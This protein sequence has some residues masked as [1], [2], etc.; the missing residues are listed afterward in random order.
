M[1]IVEKGWGREEIWADQPEYCGK[2]L[3]FEAGKSC[4]MHF[5]NYKDETWFVQ[6]G[7]FLVSWIDTDNA[8]LNARYLSPGDTWRNPPLFPHQ[9]SCEEAGVIVEVSTHDDPADNY[10]VLPGDSQR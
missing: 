8:D 4:S 7:S 3:V 6:S 2:N 1:R 10:R 5:H 9:L